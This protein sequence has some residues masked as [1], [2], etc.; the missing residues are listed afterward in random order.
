MGKDGATRQ[1]RSRQPSTHSVEKGVLQQEKMPRLPICIQAFEE[2]DVKLK[3]INK[4]Q[5]FVNENWLKKE[6]QK[7][8]A[9]HCDKIVDKYPEQKCFIKGWFNRIND[10]STKCGCDTILKSKH[11]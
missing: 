4:I 3:R 1:L 9:E 8:R 7:S 11:L 10:I 6:L 2:P 5:L